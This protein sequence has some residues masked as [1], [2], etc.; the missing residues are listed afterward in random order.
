MIELAEPVS[1]KPIKIQTGSEAI[2]EQNDIDR[3]GYR[4]DRAHVLTVQGG[5]SARA[6][7]D[8]V[9]LLLH[10]CGA[11]HGESGSALLSFDGNDPQVVK[12]V[13]AGSKEGAAPSSLAVPS[14]T[15]AA[16]VAKA[17]NR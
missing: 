2:R 15:F 4:G 12:I 10:S 14:I 1:L 13:V 6:I 17:L 5:C 8:P 9:P 3:A 11:V 16:A 7:L